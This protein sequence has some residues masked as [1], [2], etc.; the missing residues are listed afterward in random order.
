MSV[1]FLLTTFIVCLA[2]GIGVI[3]TLST[4]LGRG[5]RAG[6]WAVLGCT[7]ATVVHLGVA[8]AGLAAVLHSSALLFSAIKY[9]GVAYLLYMA[10]GTL[11]GSG[12]PEVTADPTPQRPLTLVRRGVLLNLLNPK[13]PMFFVAFLPQFIPAR[14]PDATLRLIE[15]GTGFVAVTFAVFLMYAM[16]A[17]WLRTRV[18]ENESVMSWIRRVFAASFAGLGAKLALERT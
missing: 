1:E 2:P 6:L 16:A 12:A 3:Y 5:F 10:W 13:L 11:R 8:L 4:T 17:G 18:V 15:L 14:A 9:A 7:L